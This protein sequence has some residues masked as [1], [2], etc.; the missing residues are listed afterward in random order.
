M[1]YGIPERV[2]III[3]F[4]SPNQCY[5]RVAQ[6][7]NGRHRD[8]NGQVYIHVLVEKFRETR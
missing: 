5:L 7:F 3:I 8:K 1:V 6:I 2:E 4:G